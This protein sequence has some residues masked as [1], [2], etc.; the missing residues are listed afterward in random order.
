MAL[1]RRKQ[2][3][4]QELMVPTSALPRSP[5]HPFY[6]ALNKL[7]AEAKFDAYVEGL[8][9]PLYRDGGRPSIPPGVFFRMLF[10]GYFEGIDSQRGIAWRCSD[11]LSLRS[12][13]GL[14]PT[15]STPDHSSLTIIRQRL[16]KELIEQVFAFVLKV[17]FEK[18][19][20]KGKAI[21]VDATTLE[22]NAAMKSIVRRDGGATWKA[23]LTKLATEAGIKEPTDDQLRQFD[24]TRK[25]KK[26]S[27]DDWQSPSDPDA[28]ITKMKD[29]TTG[30]GYKA[31]HAVDLDTEIVV[32]ADVKPADAADG[33]TV[34]DTVV[35]AQGNL[36]DATKQECRI[37][38]VVADKGYHKASTLAWLDEREVRT[39]IPQRRD[40][41]KR[42]WDDKPEGWR[43]AVYENRRRVE[44]D[45]GKQY[46][47]RRAEV[48]ERSFAHLCTTG[49]SRRT[50]IRGMAEVGKRYLVSVM[51]HNLGVILRNLIGAGKPREWASM[52][53]LLAALDRFWSTICSRVDAV[54]RQLA[55]WSTLARGRHFGRRDFITGSP[56][57]AC[58][59]GC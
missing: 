38:E 13:L 26:T 31:E 39:Y 56:S 7:L 34:K 12:F 5:G 32:A 52:R 19:L 36:N 55:D 44:R 20:L 30:L 28:R 29:G 6:V 10:I 8:C 50:W 42:R 43:E 14:K 17:A 9:E 25:G 59:T 57:A 18:K 15:E 37:T 47:R 21:G 2:S 48:V 41:R 24:R 23:Y 53:A 1:G 27:N 58:S 16:S 33:E 49:G 11:S 46:Q 54:L 3:F 51:A 45:K 4:Q 40:K 35:E 22:A